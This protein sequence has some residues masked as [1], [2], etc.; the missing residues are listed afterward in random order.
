VL[1]GVGQLLDELRLTR[2][3]LAEHGA[4]AHIGP[5]RDG[6]F[7]L[8]KSLPPTL[9]YRVKDGL[10]VE[11]WDVIQDDASREQSRSGLPMF[12]DEFPK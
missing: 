4:R 12:G 6:L 8:V 10:L 5:G 2:R 9:E 7:G 1:R 3:R 11:H